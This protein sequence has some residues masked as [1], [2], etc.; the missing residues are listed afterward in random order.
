MDMFGNQVNKLEQC[1][2]AGENAIVFGHLS[3][4]AMVSLDDIGVEDQLSDTRRIL[5]ISTQFGIVLFPR[6]DI[7]RELPIQFGFEEF[8][9]DQGL[10][11]L[12]FL[13]LKKFSTVFQ[14]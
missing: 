6:T 9:F 2:I 13:H 11:M 3:D 5:K 4:L 7:H 12:C 8:Q 10:D 14:I 1:H